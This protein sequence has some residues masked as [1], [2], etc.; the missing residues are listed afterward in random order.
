M[1]GGS[2]RLC[3]V[4]CIYILTNYIAFA[5]GQWGRLFT[6]RFSLLHWYALTYADDLVLIAPIIRTLFDGCY[7][8]AM[9]IMPRN[10]MFCLMLIRNLCAVILFLLHQAHY[11][12]PFLH[13]ISGHQVAL[14]CSIFSSNCDDC[15]DI[16][17]IKTSFLVQINRIICI[18][19]SKH[20]MLNET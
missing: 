17:S 7:R 15:D 16:L 11:C 12:L 9:M 1:N 8:L 6:L 20:V 19:F 2:L 4:L 10:I 3:F 5:V 18:K 13:R 14:S